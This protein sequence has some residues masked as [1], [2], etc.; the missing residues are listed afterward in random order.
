[1]KGVFLKKEKKLS[2][3]S[4]FIQILHYKCKQCNTDYLYHYPY[5]TIAFAIVIK[6]KNFDIS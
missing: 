3:G 1:M 6:R 4:I 5:I 2:D